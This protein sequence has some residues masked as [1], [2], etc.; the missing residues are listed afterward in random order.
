MT[1]LLVTGANRGLGLEFVQQYAADGVDVIACCRAPAKAEALNALVKTARNL[2]IAALDVADPS[3]AA[4]LKADLGAQ[5]IDIVINNAGIGG[6]SD[7]RSIDA[8]AW[9][10]ILRVNALGPMLV[11]AA[12]REN[13]IRGTDKKIVT[14]TS[15]LGL[16][17]GNTS[18]GWAPYRAS[19]AAVNSFMRTLAVEWARDGIAVA[20]LSPG[21]VRTDMGGATAQLSPQESVAA[22]RERIA[23][24][25]LKTTGRFL[26]HTGKE[27]AW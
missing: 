27:I 13:L 25:S 19:K 7:T 21:W 20:I 23:E 16:N 9:L 3:S 10:N 4:S 18:G 15:G 11:S 24:L 2:R 22:L 6:P 12:L 26:G 17:G 1:T 14:I 5:P 8:E